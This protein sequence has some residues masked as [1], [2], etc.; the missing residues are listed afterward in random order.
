VTRL[1]I[2]DDFTAKLMND[3]PPELL[4]FLKTRVNSFVK[5]DMI[6]FFHENPETAD[7][8]ENIARY[9]GRGM[10]IVEPELQEMV[11][12]GLLTVRQLNQM[13]VYS[14]TADDDMRRL[15][16][17]FIAACDD[18]NFRVKAVYHIIRGMR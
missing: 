9:A 4:E 6:R 17:D 16:G 8:V 18:R 3:M 5:W 12:N 2:D 1:V 11:D 15:I 7:T 14:L 10:A 13:S